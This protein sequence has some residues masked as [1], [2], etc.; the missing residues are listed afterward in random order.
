MAQLM[1]TPD[2]RLR[3]QM[4]DAELKKQAL[5]A[6]LADVAKERLTGDEIKRVLKS[7]HPSQLDAV[8]LSLTDR[9]AQ[10]TTDRH[11]KTG[12]YLD[13]AVLST[14]TESELVNAGV[15]ADS[16]QRMKQH[17]ALLDKHVINPL[18]KLGRD[19]SVEKLDERAERLDRMQQDMHPK[20]MP[21]DQLPHEARAA[22]ERTRA[23]GKTD[24]N[25]DAE[26]EFRDSLSK[27]HELKSTADL[28]KAM[29]KK[30]DA[31]AAVEIL[32]KTGCLSNF[33][34]GRGDDLRNL[35]PDVRAQHDIS[36]LYAKS[37]GDVFE[38]LRTYVQAEGPGKALPL[39]ESLDL[40]PRFDSKTG[41]PL[42]ELPL[43]ERVEKYM[44][45]L[46][47]YKN[48][49]I[50]DSLAVLDSAKANTEGAKDVDVAASPPGAKAPSSD[51]GS[52]AQRQ[53][54]KFVLN[55][56]AMVVKYTDGGA[57]I[58]EDP[59]EDVV[60]GKISELAGGLRK[61]MASGGRIVGTGDDFIVKNAQGVITVSG[62]NMLRV[63]NEKLQEKQE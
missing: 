17:K 9:K 45:G 41:K 28:A 3:A 47:K 62:E 19:L 31:D 40:V 59:K 25:T 43:E 61:I 58:V 1:Q 32:R 20:T 23:Q 24:T 29:L 36:R 42:I 30:G 22:I 33:D 6:K 54:Q 4:S 63:F 12:V 8:G 21:Q 51:V 27:A 13:G 26:K 5:D 38:S 46:E 14:Y 57:D 39:A 35:P 10:N 48:L 55:D 18:S 52:Q 49:F 16:I 37:Y 34:S 56:E 11:W 2:G 50:R 60:R 44:T 15:G 53:I 7:I